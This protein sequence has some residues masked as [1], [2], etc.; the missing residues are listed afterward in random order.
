MIATIAV[1]DNTNGDIYVQK[2]GQ[3]DYVDNEKAQ[4]TVREF[5]VD[6][7]WAR[8]FAQ[9]AKMQSYDYDELIEDAACD[10]VIIGEIQYL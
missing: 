3:F 2:L 4:E 9:K 10:G 7:Y 6:N 8:E 1:Y 5:P